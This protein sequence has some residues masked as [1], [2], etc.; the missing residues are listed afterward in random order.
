MSIFHRHHETSPTPEYVRAARIGAIN[1]ALNSFEPST[2]PYSSEEKQLEAAAVIAGL[3]LLIETAPEKIATS[4]WVLTS[5]LFP[6][7]E[8]KGQ[9]INGYE[10]P[11]AVMGTGLEGN[12]GFDTTLP[13]QTYVSFEA[14]VAAK[15]PLYGGEIEFFN[16]DNHRT[17]HYG[18]ISIIG[19]D[20]VLTE[21]LP[22]TLT[23][24][25][26]ISVGR[27]GRGLPDDLHQASLSYRVALPDRTIFGTYSTSPYQEPHIDSLKPEHYG[28]GIVDPAS[29]LSVINS[30]RRK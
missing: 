26:A 11:N 6:R 24:D 3:G 23:F 29:V 15:G 27:A 20:R 22:A 1:N 21:V 8:Y 16:P 17:A 5:T 9:V 2:Y 13:H 19:N 18:P 12:G 28:Q 14:S 4:P 7:R 30:I 10:K 25:G